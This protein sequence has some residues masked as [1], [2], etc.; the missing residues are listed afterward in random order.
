[1]SY[2]ESINVE[3]QK[4][5]QTDSMLRD[6]YQIDVAA[7]NEAYEEAIKD[8]LYGKF[9]AFYSNLLS[10]VGS[11]IDQMKLRIRSLADDYKVEE[12]DGAIDIEEAIGKYGFADYSVELVEKC[13][14]EMAKITA[15]SSPEADIQVVKRLSE[16]HAMLR[17]VVKRFDEFYYA[18]AR[19]AAMEQA[20]SDEHSEDLER[21]E[22]NLESELNKAY[23]TA[24]A[25]IA[26][27]K[28]TYQQITDEFLEERFAAQ[29][30][31]Q[32][33]AFPSK[34]CLG[35]IVHPVE[36]YR[37]DVVT[38][39]LSCGNAENLFVAFEMPL[40]GSFD[41]YDETPIK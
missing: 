22:N 30:G 3:L 12:Y 21:L 39:A 37:R 11:L 33:T 41:S 19:T 15:S 23:N 5:K 20:A 13:N 38:K 26:R 6:R 29:I 27:Y 34:I 36:D 2:I 16:Y 40:V 28:A 4:L 24:L 8:V 14:R 10:S 25:N 1:M 9:K 31:K 18:H 32:H 35:G 7:V 17:E